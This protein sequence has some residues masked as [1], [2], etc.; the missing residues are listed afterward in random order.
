MTIG[1]NFIDG[2]CG[3]G[4]EEKDFGGGGEVRRFY[5]AKYLPLIPN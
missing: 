5:C 1:A 3:K 4:N 2:S